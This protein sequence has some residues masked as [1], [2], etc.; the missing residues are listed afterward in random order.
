M[1]WR[2]PY[3]RAPENRCVRIYNLVRAY[4]IWRAPYIIL[5]A[6]YS[7]WR[8]PYIRAPENICVRIY[9]LVR[10]YIIWRAPYI[11]WRAPYIRWCAQYIRARICSRT[12]GVANSMQKNARLTLIV[13]PL[14]GVAASDSRCGCIRGQRA[15]S[16]RSRGVAARGQSVIVRPIYVR[17]QSLRQNAALPSIR[18]C[19]RGRANSSC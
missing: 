16:D 11:I 6:P 13:R 18:D 10:A 4:M 1:R 15:A 7:R 2:A 14:R 3:I 5:R 12:S 17:P 8:A 19:S 9:F